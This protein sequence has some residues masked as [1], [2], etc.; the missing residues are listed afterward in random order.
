MNDAARR[1]AAITMV[2]AAL[3]GAGIVDH[4][5]TERRAG[6]VTPPA[7]AIPAIRVSQPAAE[8]SGWYCVGGTGASGGAPATIVLTNTTDRMVT[9][10][11]TVATVGGVTGT[12]PVTVP[13]EGQ[14]SVVP[15]QIAS[16]TWLAA[17]VVLD[18]GG[19][20]V[21]QSVADPL[22]WSAAPCSAETAPQWW[23]A[24]GSTAP[25]NALQLSLFNP[26]STDA[27]V[28][29]TL[30]TSD[31]G[32]LQPP[33]YQGVS[34]PAGGVASVNL[35]DHASGHA[36]MATEVTALRGSI[37]AA[38]LQGFG[39]AAFGGLSLNIGAPS[40]SRQWAFAQSTSVSGGSVVF[41]VFNP[42]TKAARVRVDLG[43][44]QGTADPLS[45]TVP[46]RSTT[47]LV[48]AQQ[49]RIPANMPFAVTFSSE[50]KVGV[51]VERQVVSPRAAA[52]AAG[53]SSGLPGGARRWLVPAVPPPGT[54]AAS[55]A[56]ADLGAKPVTVTVS[57]L[58]V[59]GPEPIAG[60]GS[61]VVGPRQPLVLAA[62][63]GALSAGASGGASAAS[64]G[65]A[66]LVVT[67][68]GPVAIELDGY[69]VGS[70]GVTVVPAFA[71]S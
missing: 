16:G 44:E 33:A 31:A 54:G 62:P 70:P 18:G 64:I 23:F 46:A 11:V 56:V 43:L 22:G 36:S 28:D 9:G 49:S 55:L 3:T 8:S 32:R 52:S 34:V 53:E 10:M 71:L 50:G 20:A 40:P 14:L 59:A 63:A 61:R 1:A 57:A 26:G 35:V 48:T 4:L 37:V 24:D 39:Q 27:V 21:S 25:G 15:A 58:T 38:Q 13:A 2:V 42:S 5:V 17:K 60:L 12:R 68:S 67:A 29:V 51:V 6:A 30:L 66:A 65:R 69:P 7:T 45:L 41:H 19:V 47:A